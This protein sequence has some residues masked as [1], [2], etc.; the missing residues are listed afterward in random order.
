MKDDRDIDIYLKQ[1]LSDNQ[2]REAFKQQMLHNSTAEF[3]RIHRRRS[4]LRRSVLTAAAILIAGIAFLG[5]R[6]SA[7]SALPRGLDS[8][9]QAAAQSEGVTVPVDLV[10]WLDAARLFRQLG[11]N[12]RMARAVE[13]AGGLLPVE[14]VTTDSRTEHMIAAEKSVA[15]QNKS[16]EPIGISGP[17][18]STDSI[19][20]I[21]AQV[22]EIEK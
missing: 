15:N 21:L 6:L 10:A 20:E 19:N 2:P 14:V 4:A 17:Q 1:H 11:M 9:P 8:A 18:A 13:R 16:I 3:I 7:P 5:G 22:L 12:D